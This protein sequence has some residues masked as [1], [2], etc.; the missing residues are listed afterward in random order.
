ME[1]TIRIV[2]Q[3]IFYCYVLLHAYEPLYE[4][5]P[6]NKQTNKQTNRFWIPEHCRANDAVCV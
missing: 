6:T 2:D 5:N 4:I 3:I 1:V